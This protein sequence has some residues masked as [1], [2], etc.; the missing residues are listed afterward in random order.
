MAYEKA[1]LLKYPP[2]KGHVPESH[3]LFCF[4]VKLKF[5]LPS[6]DN[7]MY[8]QSMWEHECSKLPRNFIFWGFA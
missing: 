5:T 3:G 1:V 8:W 7:Q 4:P 6:F 2:W